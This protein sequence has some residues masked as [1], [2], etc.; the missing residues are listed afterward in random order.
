LLQTSWM[1]LG[2]RMAPKRLHKSSC[3]KPVSLLIL[4]G[5]T[6]EIFYSIVQNKFLHDIRFKRTNIKGRGNVNRDMLGEIYKYAYSNR[7]DLVRVYCCIDTERQKKS[8]TP[9]DLGF[10]CEQVQAR[11]MTCVLSI[12]AILADPDIESWFFYDINGIYKFLGVR[13]SQRSTK[14]YRNPKNL[15]KKELQQLFRRFDKVYLPGRKATHLIN[16]LDIE[17]IVA[18]CETLRE[19]ILLIQS[20][21]DD[22]TN[23][24]FPDKK[25]KK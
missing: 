7:R 16:N 23:H 5:D 3:D 6:E 19:G 12:S 14:K 25:S 21:A 2:N 20:K 4:E 13:K 24:L 10:V 22:L 11:Q 8:A 9:F 1:F 18:N 15:C 17:K